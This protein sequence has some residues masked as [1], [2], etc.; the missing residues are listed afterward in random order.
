M[1]QFESA[2]NQFLERNAGVVFI[3]A[4]KIDGLFKGKEH[5]EKRKYPFPVLFDET[6]EVTR[7]YGVHHALGIDAYN[8]AR[9]A[10][11]VVGGEGKICWIAVS[12]QQ[13]EAPLVE[14]VL[15]AIEACGKY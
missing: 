11:F 9:R 13:R 6:R 15:S 5:V 1:T 7:A 14:D 10:V 2:Y 4:Q 3:A 12:P 8:I